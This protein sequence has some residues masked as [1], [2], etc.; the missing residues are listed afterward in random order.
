MHL[1]N[2]LRKVLYEFLG[3]EYPDVLSSI[4]AALKA[5][6]NV[7]GMEEMQPPIKDLLPSLTPI[8]KNRHEKV[9]ESCIDLAGRIADRGSE[10]VSPRER[11]SIA[12]ELLD[13]LK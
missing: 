12:Y 10:Y 11:M 1:L 3:E 13:M 2:H 4:L 5:V 6:V 9:Q 7:V 8:M